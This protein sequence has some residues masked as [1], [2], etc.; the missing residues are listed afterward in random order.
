ML[1]CRELV[2]SRASDY[3]D[4]Q[5]NWRARA[6]VRFHLL[7]CHHCRRFMQQLALVR[8]L[9]A[10]WPEPVPGETEL[11]SLAERLYREHRHRAGHPPE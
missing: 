5:L 10:G 4:S 6:G 9:L 8:G 11:S 7:I 2:Q 1:T 3:L